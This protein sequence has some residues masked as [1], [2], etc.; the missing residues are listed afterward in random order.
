MLS[1]QS[2]LRPLIPMRW[3]EVLLLQIPALL[4]WISRWAWQKN[5][6]KTPLTLQILR[7]ASDYLKT[8]L[9]KIPMEQTW[10]LRPSVTAAENTI[11]AV[12]GDYYGA[13]STGYV[14]RNGGARYGSWRLKQMVTQ[15]FTRM[16]PSRL[17]L[18]RWDSADQLVKDGV[19]SL[20]AFGPS[21]SNGNNC[22][23]QFRGGA[24]HLIHELRLGSSVKT[25]HI[26]VSDGW[27]QRGR[28]F[29]STN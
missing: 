1:K 20:L 2:K 28:A 3:G 21:L 8:A 6:W 9:P 16:V 5:S 27:L 17:P 26:I 25:T 7:L 11:L 13:N 10:R 22:R 19:V 4:R 15:R 29:L 23:Y 24:I 12:N 14:I 18:R